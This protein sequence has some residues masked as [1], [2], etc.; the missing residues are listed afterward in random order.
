[1]PQL[2]W[3]E[4]ERP[5]ETERVLARIRETWEGTPFWRLMGFRVQAVGPAYARISMPARTD[6]RNDGEGPVHG[7]A[8]AALVDVAVT[9]ALWTVYDTEADLETHTT[10]ELNISYLAPGQG[11]TMIA[12]ARGLRKGSSVFVGDVDVTGEDGALVARGRATY[13]VWL[14]KTALR[15]SGKA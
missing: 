4:S 14:K 5:F 3:P 11:T 9:A 1:M 13:R 8:L 7:G 12:V 6:L 10:I 2:L 15:S